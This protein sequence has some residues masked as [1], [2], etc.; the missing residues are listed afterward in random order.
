[1]RWINARLLYIVADLLGT[2][3][4]PWDGYYCVLLIVKDITLAQDRGNPN[5]I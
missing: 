3:V 5:V 1:M 2:E 4:S